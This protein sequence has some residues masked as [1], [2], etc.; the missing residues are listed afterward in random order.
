M[1]PDKTVQRVLPLL[2]SEYRWSFTRSWTI[3]QI[4]QPDTAYDEASCQEGSRRSS[5]PKRRAPTQGK[6][7]AT[8]TKHLAEQQATDE[9]QS[10]QQKL[11]PG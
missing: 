4:T 7:V 11:A 6:N 2:L 10:S 9:T 3:Q 8:A 5:V 1:L